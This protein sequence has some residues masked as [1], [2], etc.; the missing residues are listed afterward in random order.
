M[1]WHH[2]C[3]TLGIYDAKDETQK[4][5]L[6]S[7]HTLFCTRSAAIDGSHPG[8]RLPRQKYRSLAS[9]YCISISTATRRYGTRYV[10]LNSRTVGLQGNKLL[11]R[12]TVRPLNVP[13]W[14][15]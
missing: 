7:I 12:T 10:F 6:R 2:S 15:G 5:N 13:L 3:E 1:A 14:K 9:T 4:G 11:S 8:M